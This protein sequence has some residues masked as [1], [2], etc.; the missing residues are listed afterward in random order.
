[1]LAHDLSALLRHRLLRQPGGFEGCLD[2][3][4]AKAE[5]F[6]AGDFPIAQLPREEGALLNPSLAS[7]HRSR[8]T[9]Q[10]DD[11]VT[12]VKEPLGFKTAV[13][14]VP[15]RPPDG[16]DFGDAPPRSRLDCLGAVDVLD[17]G[18]D[19]GEEL[20]EVPAVPGIDHATNDLHVLLRHHPAVSRAKLLLSM[21]SASFRMGA[22]RAGGAEIDFRHPRLRVSIN[23]GDRTRAPGAP[24]CSRIGWPPG[25]WD[26]WSKHRWGS[27]CSSAGSCSSTS[28]S[29][30]CSRPAPAPPGTRRT[31]SPSPARRGPEPTS[32]Y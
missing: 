9:T 11:L 13:Q 19:N 24:S 25:R 29:S 1:M 3:A 27:P 18:I 4:P 20:I 2:L 26:I 10:D 21:Q 12:P 28:R 14:D 16:A 17:P 5:H 30:R 15:L 32:C 8:D 22:T 6:E 7:G 23:F 31:R